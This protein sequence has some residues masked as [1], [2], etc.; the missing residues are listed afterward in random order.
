VIRTFKE[1]CVHRKVDSDPF[2]FWAV[3]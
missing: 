2:L 1:Q 3:V